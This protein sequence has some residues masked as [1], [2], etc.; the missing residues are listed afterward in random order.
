M[1]SSRFGDRRLAIIIGVSLAVHGTIA[2]VALSGDPPEDHALLSASSGRI[3]IPDEVEQEIV[4]DADHV[5]DLLSPPVPHTVPAP[6]VAPPA[7]APPAVAPPAPGP[8]VHRAPPTR[9]ADPRSSQQV[10]DSLFSDDHGLGPSGDI[11]RRSPGHDLG[12]QIDQA[13]REGGTATIGGGDP[14]LRGDDHARTGTGTDC[15][16]LDAPT[17]T[18]QIPARTELPPTL[19]VHSDPAQAEPTTLDPDEVLRI[20]TT[21]YMAGLERCQ[22]ELFRRTAD[23]HG[24]VTLDLTIDAS[25]ATVSPDA[26]GFDD[27]LDRCVEARAAAWQFP[28]PHAA[29]GAATSAHYRVSLVLQA[30]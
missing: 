24:K 8:G 16:C 14:R 25:G 26:A 3:Y 15:D 13:K 6:A 18:T 27:G 12:A 20:I 22:S 7:V 4:F 5:P 19:R 11:G 9:L 1:A 10:V 23:A 28:V 17:T 29:S 30:K 21:K 2:G